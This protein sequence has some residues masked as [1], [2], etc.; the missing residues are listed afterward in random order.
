MPTPVASGRPLFHDIVLALIIV[1][2][3]VGDYLDATGERGKIAAI[4]LLLNKI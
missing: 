3:K 4:K 2:P 1:F